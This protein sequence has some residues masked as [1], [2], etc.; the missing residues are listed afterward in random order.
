MN[1]VA[2]LGGT[3]DPIHNGHISIALKV[4][5]ELS[6]DE[7]WFMPNNKSPFK[8]DKK[9]ASAVDRIKMIKLAINSHNRLKVCDYE[10]SNSDVSYTYNTMKT[11]VELYPNNKF[12]FIIGADQANSL[13]HWYKIEGLKELVTLI[14]LKRE[15]YQLDPIKDAIM[16]DNDFYKVSSSEEKINGFKNI[17][18]EVKDYIKEMKLYE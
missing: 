14:I 12:Y 2:I 15:G 7:V 4:I 16:I 6:L 13:D 3:F 11:L 10:I 1:Q 9:I 17:N 5:E 8:L 18:E